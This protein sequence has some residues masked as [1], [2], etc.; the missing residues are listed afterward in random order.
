MDSNKRAG[1]FISLAIVIIGTYI[2]FQAPPEVPPEPALESAAA[3]A[4]LAHSEPAAGG[5]E[6]P[7]GRPSAADKTVQFSESATV[8]VEKAMS[9]RVLG[10]EDA[11]VTIH[12]F[13]S[14]TCSHCASFHNTAFKQLKEQYIDTGKVRFIFT[15]FPLNTAAREAA[16]VARCLPHE[17]YFQFIAFLMETQDKWA[18]GADYRKSLLQNAKLVGGSGEKLEACLKSEELEYALLKQ[19]QDYSQQYDIQS[20]PSFV[21]N[22]QEVIRG[23]QPFSFLQQKIESLLKES[24]STE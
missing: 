22:G 11:L 17:R 18:F 10:A 23:A 13:A 15:D 7:V 12:E 3:P 20:T 6:A 1:I 19:M 24:S 9:Q 5:E 14:L 4:R 16:I 8:D 21:I 2:L